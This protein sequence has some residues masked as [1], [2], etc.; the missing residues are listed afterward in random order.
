MKLFNTFCYYLRNIPILIV[1]MFYY[2]VHPVSAGYKAATAL[3]Y[4][5]QE[6]LKIRQIVQI[7]LANQGIVLG[8]ISSEVAQPTFKTREITAIPIEIILPAACVTLAEWMSEFYATPFGICL[9]L[10]IP[11]NLQQKGRITEQSPS[12]TKC[13]DNNQLS[14]DQ[15]MALDA[16]KRLDGD[17]M[18]I[19]GDTGSG[20]TRLYIEMI[21]AKP[22]ENGHVIVLTP[23][24]SLVPQLVNTLKAEFQEEVVVVHSQLTD[25]A[26]R[27][28]WLDIYSSETRKIIVGPRSVLFGPYTKIGLI[29]VDEM[30]ENAYKQEQ[31]PRYHTL[32]V[33]GY[34]HTLHKSNLVLGSATPS[35]D[36][37][38]K[39]DAQKKKIVRLQR[40]VE[41]DNK[42]VEIV[43]Y[44]DKQAFSKNTYL[45][46]ALLAR[47]DTSLKKGMQSLVLL[48]RRGT[49]RVVLCN[50]C[51]WQL[52][53]SHCDT[54]LTYHQD[55]H[56]AK[57]H[58][59]GQA[60]QVPTSCPEC[61]STDLSF[62]SAGT[63]LITSELQKIFPNANIGRYDTD[64]TKIERFEQQYDAIRSGNID[65]IVGTQIVAKG[66]DLDS[67]GVVGVLQADTGLIFPD[68]T[69][70][71]KTYQ[72]LYQVLGRV[73]RR[74]RTD[75]AVIQTFM[76]KSQLLHHV[77]EG[78]W[79]DF[80]TTQLSQR[81]KY[82]F[83][84][85]AHLLK[86]ST[87]KKTSSSAEKNLQALR[88]R[89]LDEYKNIVVE[90]PTPS[91]IEKRSGAYYWHLVLKSK[92]RK[93]LQEIAKQY[94]LKYT[95]D[96]D[97]T[98]II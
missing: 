35:V 60:V 84:P 86:I 4:A 78:N 15:R 56:N 20:K 44:K 23:E 88:T 7:P 32:R 66:L 16:Y 54:N 67:L 58:T 39:L 42:E 59:C 50:T 38:Y 61:T 9:S 8:L 33:A 22:N 31:Q 94:N 93:A 2:E 6:A 37:F 5:S 90:N 47:I 40:I 48:N 80:Y 49:A 69:A 25:S 98:T 13:V 43:D 75:F 87:H 19:H 65:I 97:P 18:L 29:I 76:P 96:L 64:N 81:Q 26:R 55:S 3:T 82:R 57:C 51:A 62:R 77:K 72:L 21:K 24:I 83:P 85:F 45:S 73:G 53:C 34:L 28:V 10:F 14:I 92:N 11:R 30:H 70:E 91:F 74:E 17:T 89:I 1:H 27:R 52:R 95:V 68:Y 41:S 63:K 46:D 12:T 71:E 79:E 36:E